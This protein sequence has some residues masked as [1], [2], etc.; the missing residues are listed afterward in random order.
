MADYTVEV[1]EKVSKGEYKISATLKKDGA[2][3][4]KATMPYNFEP[5]K[6]KNN[7][8]VGEVVAMAISKAG[9]KGK[10][11]GLRSSKG[12]INTYDV[13]MR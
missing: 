6:K 1:S 8:S 13:S 10:L 4:S 11:A 2:K 3:V 7:T 9:M 12:M 5:D